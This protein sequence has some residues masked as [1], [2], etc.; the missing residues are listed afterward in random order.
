VTAFNAP[1]T[2]PSAASSSRRETFM[3]I[4]MQARIGMIMMCICFLMPAPRASAGEPATQ[5]ATDVNKMTHD[6]LI[7]TCQMLQERVASLEAEVS[8]LRRSKPVD[9][10]AVDEP[11][12]A[13]SWVVR[14]ESNNPPDTTAAKE[15]IATER[16]HLT[17]G[18]STVRS[19]SKGGSHTSEMTSSARASDSIE[20]NLRN[21]RDKYA[22]MSA[23]KIHAIDNNGKGYYKSKYSDT[24]LLELKT[25]VDKLETDRRNSMQKITKLEA[26]IR[27]AEQI[28]T[29]SASLPDGTGVV[30]RSTPA[31]AQ[32]VSDLVV[33]KKYRITGVQVI[34]SNVLTITVQ[35]TM[36]T[37]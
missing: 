33:G 12:P 11:T 15:Q 10:H 26:Q 24:D 27:D 25:A 20:N 28:R 17:G 19:E 29:V 30:L 3:T 13:S 9:V 4:N 2:D 14:I 23:E 8:A 16:A 34:S 31:S 21:A 7:V 35:A 1:R 22:R 37:E 32:F 5:P 36:A 18:S 6:E